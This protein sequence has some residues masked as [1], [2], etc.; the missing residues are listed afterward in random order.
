MELNLNEWNIEGFLIKRDT[1]ASTSPEE[2]L[3]IKKI[4]LDEPIKNQFREILKSHL[5]DESGNL[6]LNLS[7]FEAFMSDDSPQKKYYLLQQELTQYNNHFEL[8]LNKLDPE[9]DHDLASDEFSGY[10]SIVI[11]VS[12]Q[13][14]EFLYFRKLNRVR[15]SKKKKFH[16]YR[17]EITTLKGDFIYFDDS[18]DFIYL[19]N[20]IADGSTDRERKRFNN[21]ILIFDRYNFKTLFKLYEYCIQEATSFFEKFDFIE[22][23]DIDT[24]K[25]DNSGNVLKLK[26]SFIQDLRLNEQIAR[27]KS[28]YEDEISLDRITALKNKRKRKYRFQ[29]ADHK[30]KI[31]TKEELEDLLDLVDEKISVPD[32]N[33]RKL[34]RYP[35]KGKAV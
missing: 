10:Y 13:S 6:I 8:L 14:Q 11:K 34:L 21:H 17:G 28:L 26:D 12:K 15:I 3:E 25:K 4:N 7:E 29:I 31:K 30:I 27:I 18:I 16:I 5:C 24:K 32:W 2:Y 20:F 9:V 23:E 33:H 22:I 1:R 35:S 19:K